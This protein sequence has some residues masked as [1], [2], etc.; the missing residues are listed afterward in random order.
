MSAEKK[1]VTIE[2]DAELHRRLK[3]RAALEGKSVRELCVETLERELQWK[4]SKPNMSGTELVE[5]LQRLQQEIFGDRV[6][7]GDSADLIR[8]AREERSRQMDQ[9]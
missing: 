5:R 3:E 8:E 4:A 7:P 6:L 9:W 2:I 1:R